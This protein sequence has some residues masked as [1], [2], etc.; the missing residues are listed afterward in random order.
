MG[1]KR[2]RLPRMETP[3]GIAA[4]AWLA[5]PDSKYNKDKPKYKLT[6][7]LE[8]DDA[9]KEF[10]ETAGQL[11]RETAKQMDDVP[12]KAAK[13]L[14]VKSGDE[15]N[16]D[17][18]EN[19]KEAIE[20]FAGKTLV[21]LNTSRPPNL[22]LPAEL[23][24]SNPDVTIMSGDRVKAKFR[25]NPYA[26]FGGGVNFQLTAVKLIEKL[27][28]GD[29]DDGFD[30]DDDDEYVSRKASGPSKGDA[31]DDGGDDDDGDGDY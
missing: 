4:F 14:P 25:V 10:L 11:A 7:V 31:D 29:D 24:E 17:R 27:A 18:V 23:V 5:K 9:T 28:F 8:D 26:G 22:F 3:I 20:E 30:D 6:L 19:E 12:A 21:T 2:V 13:K 15:F 1:E 16:E